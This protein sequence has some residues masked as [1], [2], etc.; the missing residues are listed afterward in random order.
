MDEVVNLSIARER[1]NML[2]DE[3]IRFLGPAA[4]GDRDL[5]IDGL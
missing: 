5:W 3:R 1:F 4:G 2:F